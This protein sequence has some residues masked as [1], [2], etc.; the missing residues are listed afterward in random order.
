MYIVE[1]PPLWLS[2]ANARV[3]FQ[4]AENRR[5]MSLC[6]GVENVRWGLL[7]RA[8]F[9]RLYT[10]FVKLVSYTLSNYRYKLLQCVLGDFIQAY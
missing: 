1:F 5:L 2:G 7:K 8:V 4:T 6:G 10:Q 3:K 9:I